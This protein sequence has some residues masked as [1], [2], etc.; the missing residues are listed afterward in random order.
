MEMKTKPY[1]YSWVEGSVRE[2]GF[3]QTVTRLSSDLQRN[4]RNNKLCLPT[5]LLRAFRCDDLI[6][7]D[8]RFDDFHPDLLTSNDFDL[9]CEQLHSIL[10]ERV[11][12]QLEERRSTLF[13]DVSRMEKTQAAALI[14]LL[15]ERRNEEMEEIE[16]TL[17]SCDLI[18]L[19]DVWATSYGFSL[20]YADALGFFE[21]NK[22]IV[23][24]LDSLRDIG[25]RNLVPTPKIS[26]EKR[27]RL[28]RYSELL[29]KIVAQISD[30]TTISWFDFNGLCQESV[31]DIFGTDSSQREKYLQE[32]ML[33]NDHLKTKTIVD[34]LVS[35]NI[36]AVENGLVS[37]SMSPTGRPVMN[38]ILIDA[39]I[40]LSERSLL[41]DIDLAPFDEIVEYFEGIFYSSDATSTIVLDLQEIGRIRRVDM[42]TFPP[43]TSYPKRHGH[44]EVDTPWHGWGLLQ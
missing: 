20:L 23:D 42:G 40:Y 5:I 18:S 7:Y 25:L 13:L 14:P 43:F 1:D 33:S 2:V 8:G 17:L 32:M 29:M 26:S 39:I 37:L 24:V 38:P 31:N 4:F 27:I 36:L 11:R 41:S 21:T 12:I 44:S 9:I 35:A 34:D 22:R 3:R 16:L 19:K 6:G 10:L 28:G 30:R 15:L